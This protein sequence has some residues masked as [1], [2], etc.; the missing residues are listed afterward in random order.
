MIASSSYC[1]WIG[2]DRKK[3]QK[4]EWC[5]RAVGSVR[6]RTARTVLRVQKD[7]ATKR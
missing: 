3:N 4:W 6:T 2:Q 7:G 5:E 1:V